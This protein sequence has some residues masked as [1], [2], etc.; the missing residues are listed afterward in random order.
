MAE[1]QR[2]VNGGTILPCGLLA[3]AGNAALATGAFTAA[4]CA[5]IAAQAKT[6]SRMSAR[7]VSQVALEMM[8]TRRSVA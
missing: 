5:A 6:G 3:Q 8:A 1:H 7:E 4:K 2:L